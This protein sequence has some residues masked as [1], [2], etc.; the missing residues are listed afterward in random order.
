MKSN[1][2]IFKK[3]T[4]L[5]LHGV[6]LLYSLCSVCSKIASAY[7]FLS[8][9]WILWYGFSLFGLAL[10]AVLWQQCIKQ[11][12]LSTAFAN[13]AVVIIW[14]LLWSAFIFK[15]AISWNMLLGI[16]IIV[17]GIYIVGTCHE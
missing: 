12:P 1:K 5:A 4:F 3:T 9:R 15:E 14:G 6:L 10:Y 8:W 16:A 17:V 7:P 2:N 11:M 13:K